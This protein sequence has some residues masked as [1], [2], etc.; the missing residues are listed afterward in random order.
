MNKVVRAI[1]FLK[2][3]TYK[4]C[5]TCKYGHMVAGYK[6]KCK[7]AETK[8]PVNLKLNVCENWQNKN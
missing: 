5:K 2:Q 7:W 4:N 6:V 3:V 8:K 1:K